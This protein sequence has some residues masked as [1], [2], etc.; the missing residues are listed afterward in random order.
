MTTLSND[1]TIELG[2]DQFS[3]KPNLKAATAVSNRF[4]GFQN[5]LAAVAG[6]DLGAIQFVIR[7]GVPLKQ[8]STDD[9]GQAVYEAGTRTLMG[10]AM[11]FITRL[12]NGGRDPDLEDTSDEDD[13][14]VTDRGNGEV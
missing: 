6:S 7:Q 3:L 8:I 14:G 2:D 4:N 12:A 9:L 1:V 5:A 11:R 10:P 13:S